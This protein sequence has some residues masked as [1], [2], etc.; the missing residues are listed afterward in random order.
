MKGK[1][2]FRRLFTVGL[3]LAGGLPLVCFALSNLYLASPKGR[4]F[5]ASKVQGISGFETSVMGSSWSPWNGISVYGI[6]IEQPGPLNTAVSSPLLTIESIHAKLAWR[7]LVLNRQV[8]LKGVEIRNPKLVLPIELL[9]QLPSQ[10]ATVSTPPVVAQVDPSTQL[11]PAPPLPTGSTP[12]TV[13]LIQQ[14]KPVAKIESVGE[15]TIPT[16]WVKFSGGGLKIVST[17]SKEP[18]YQISDLKGA[19]PLGGKHANSEIVLK[20]IEFLGKP[21][22]DTIKIPL[23]WRSP[24][25]EVGAF[26]GELFGM[27]CEAVASIAISGAIPFQINAVLPEQE[28]QEIGFGENVNAKFGSL[29]AQGVFQG[30]LTFPATWQGQWI[31]QAASIDTSYASQTAHFD[32]GQTMVIFR[33]GALSCIDARLVGEQ[34]TLIGNATLLSDGRA[35]ANGRIIA[36]PETLVAISKFTEPNSAAPALTPLSTPQRSAL[37]LQFFG[38][39]GEFYFK[40][41]PRA[42][43]IPLN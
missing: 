9:S 34:L 12:E 7:A 20:Q 25:L 28:N 16:V 37:D 43:A 33:N 24:V 10:P 32:Q 2:W 39:L 29:A 21:L 23:K 27:D 26:G 35:A 17:K 11:T 13:A 15:S 18:L 40:P 19:A 41:N 6:R 22:V 38:K 36:A 4:I 42:A 30:Q 3:V 1:R 5:V 14:K 8:L 31:T